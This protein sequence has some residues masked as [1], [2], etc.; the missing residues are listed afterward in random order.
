MS[1]FLAELRR[2]CLLASRGSALALGPV[3]FFALGATLFSLAA[4]NAH[5]YAHG[6]VWVLA[7]FANALAAEGLFARDHEDGT[8]ELLLLAHPQLAAILGKLLAHWLV[9]A[10]PL[11][12]LSPIALFVLQGSLAG[13]GALLLA[14]ALSTPTLACLSAIGAALTVGTGRHGL[15]LSLLTLPLAIP[16]LAFGMVASTVGPESTFALLMLAALLTASL[17]A[18]P[19]AI[20]KALAIGQEY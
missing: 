6:V 14:L 16:V 18:A 17:T 12:L 15:L 8:L 1:A 3:V 4:G 11:L 10:L 13:A 20:A 9:S 19:F 5:G 2:E 7:L